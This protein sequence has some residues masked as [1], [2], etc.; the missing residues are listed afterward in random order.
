V[1]Q[2]A[3]AGDWKSDLARKAVG[4]IAQEGIEEAVEDAFQDIAFDAAIN[5]LDRG[6][7]NAIPNETIGSNAGDAIEAAW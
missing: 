1:S 2:L 3:A 6:V 5:T 7:G 4:R